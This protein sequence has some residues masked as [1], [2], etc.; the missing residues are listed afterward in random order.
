MKNFGFT[1]VICCVALF[2]QI[3]LSVLFLRN[4]VDE[5]TNFLGAMGWGVAAIFTLA[6]II[7]NDD[8]EN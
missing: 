1:E 7:R 3:S 6:V 4:L 8:N 2:C 5:N